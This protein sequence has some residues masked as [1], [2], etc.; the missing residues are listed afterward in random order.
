MGCAGEEAE[1]GMLPAALARARAAG[2][3]TG[4]CS[5][6]A[7]ARHAGDAGGEGWISV[8]GALW[9]GGERATVG[10]EGTTASPPASKKEGEDAP[11]CVRVERRD[12][13]PVLA[14][15]LTW[16]PPAD[17]CDCDEP[18]RVRPREL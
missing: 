2:A 18:V 14:V 8:D 16:P 13:S 12:R 10:D 7:L 3:G 15:A 1:E 9:A 17:S 11:A 5:A 4:G 6:L